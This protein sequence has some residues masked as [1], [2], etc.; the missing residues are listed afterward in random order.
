MSSPMCAEAGT[1]AAAHMTWVPT[2]LPAQQ[3]RERHT[4]HQLQPWQR[5]HLQPTISPGAN[6]KLV[7]CGTQHGPVDV[8]VL[9]KRSRARHALQWHARWLLQTGLTHS[10]LQSIR[11]VCGDACEAT[12]TLSLLYPPADGLRPQPPASK[13]GPGCRMP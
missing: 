4:P 9:G 1:A 2:P 11:I 13:P 3:R 7:G 5:K 12:C 8:C 6:N 10:S